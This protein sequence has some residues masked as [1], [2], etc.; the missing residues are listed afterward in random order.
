MVIAQDRIRDVS[1]RIARQLRRTGSSCSAP[2]RT[3]RRTR[4][5]T[6]TCWSSCH[7]RASRTAKL[8]RSQPP[9]TRASRSTSWPA[10]RTTPNVAIVRPIHWCAKRSIVAGFLYR[11]PR[12]TDEGGVKVRDILRRLQDDGWYLDRMRGSHRQLKH[13]TKPGVVTVPG[14]PNDD[15]ATRDT[16]QYPESGRIASPIVKG[17]VMRR[18]AVVIEKAPGNYSAYVPDLPGCV[19]YRCH[20]RGD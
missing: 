13:P 12:R 7:S 3:G 8:P 2:T 18:Y 16:C 9:S 11:A 1:Q 14:K 20:R 10:V 17:E 5:R 4:A 6:S 15:L 19:A